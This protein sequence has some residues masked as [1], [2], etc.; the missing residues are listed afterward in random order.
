MQNRYVMEGWLFANF[1]A[2]IAYYKLHVKLRQA[3]LLSKPHKLLSYSAALIFFA[4]RI[5]NTRENA[6][7]V[8]IK[9]TPQ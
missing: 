6:T 4:F 5:Q 8:R 3:E 2:M 7:F 1:V 9:T